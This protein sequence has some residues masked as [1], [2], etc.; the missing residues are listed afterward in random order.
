MKIPTIA[1]KNKL[2][3]DIKYAYSEGVALYRCIQNY[4]SGILTDME[5]IGEMR[6]IKSTHNE[7]IKA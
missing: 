1:Q 6:R 5:F 7:A 2:P 4:E 3:L